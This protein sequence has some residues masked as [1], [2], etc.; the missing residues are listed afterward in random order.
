MTENTE[1]EPATPPSL[2]E[3]LLGETNPV[4]RALYPVVAAVVAL[5]VFYGR[6]DPGSV[7][8]WLALAVAVLGVGGTEAA[9]AVAWAP[10]TAEAYADRVA[11]VWQTYAEDEYARGVAAGAEI[12]ITPDQLAAKTTELR[13]PGAHRPDRCREVEDGRRCCLPP[14]RDPSEG[15]VPHKFD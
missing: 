9:R 11:E 2:L 13:A 4:R 1:N 12:D 14:H 5:L 10:R 15:G 7:P 6:L 8:L 3:R